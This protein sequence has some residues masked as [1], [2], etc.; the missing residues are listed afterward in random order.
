MIQRACRT[1]FVG[2]SLL[3]HTG[4]MLRLAI[5]TEITVSPLYEHCRGAAQS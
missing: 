2:I 5:Y 3:K 1:V 4:D